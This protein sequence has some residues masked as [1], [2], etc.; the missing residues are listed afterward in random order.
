MKFI[1]VMKSYTIVSY[2]TCK[3]DITVRLFD[4]NLINCICLGCYFG[5]TGDKYQR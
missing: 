4:K 5:L 3:G 2:S 1:F